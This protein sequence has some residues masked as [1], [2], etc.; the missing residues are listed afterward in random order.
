MFPYPPRDRTLWD[1]GKEDKKIYVRKCKSE[2]KGGARRE[3]ED[4]DKDIQRIEWVGS[5]RWRRGSEVVLETISC[6]SVATFI[7]I[8]SVY[9]IIIYK[10]RNN[11]KTIE[12]KIKVQHKN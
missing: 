10:I 5:Y 11:N 9:Q 1:S 2:K 12:S 7:I 3:E 4:I 8:Y 6:C